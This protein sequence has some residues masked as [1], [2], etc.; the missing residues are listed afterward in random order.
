M[1][2]DFNPDV[3]NRPEELTQAADQLGKLAMY[4]AHK[5]EAVRAR[6]RGDIACAMTQEA[7]CDT[8]YAQL[9]PDLRW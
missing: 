8:I 2:I 9:D 5:S 1:L 4:C 3:M 6:L 7:T